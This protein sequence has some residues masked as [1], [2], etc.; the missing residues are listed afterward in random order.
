MP[1]DL[2]QITK[3]LNIVTGYRATAATEKK[4]VATK[5]ATAKEEKSELIADALEGL[6]DE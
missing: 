2:G 6:F 3:A 1:T 4:V 5:R